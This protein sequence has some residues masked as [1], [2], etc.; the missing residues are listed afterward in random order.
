MLREKEKL[1][2]IDGT[3]LLYR[4]YYALPPLT[5]TQGVPTGAV[6]GFTRMLM[7]LLKEKKE[8]PFPFRGASARCM[9]K[10]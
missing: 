9:R 6:Y 8:S 5:N 1:T 4:A 10:F 7:K 2:L 3:G